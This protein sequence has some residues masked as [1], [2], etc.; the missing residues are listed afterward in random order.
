TYRIF[1]R[2][3]ASVALSLVTL[4]TIASPGFG[5]SLAGLS[6]LGGTVR[7]KSGA[8][9]PEAS[10]TVSNASLGIERKAMTSADGYFLAPS[11][12]PSIGYEVTVEKIGFSKYVAKNIQLIVGQNVTL[13][14]DLSVS[15]QIETVTVSDAT[16]LVETSKTG[17]SVAVEQD[18][19]Q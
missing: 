15:Q 3:G 4:L 11:L 8:S 6:A 18:Q 12:T 16:P 14:V 2:A 13:S 19:I 17:V 7:D 10:V 5:Q 1:Q 9:V